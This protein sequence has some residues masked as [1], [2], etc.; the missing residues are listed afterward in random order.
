M[1]RH[2]Y[3]LAEKDEY[4]HWT[5][6]SSIG[7]SINSKKEIIDALERNWQWHNATTKTIDRGEYLDIE[8]TF[9][10]L[11]GNQLIKTFSY[12]WMHLDGAMTY[13]N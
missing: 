10:N 4:G 11:F 2:K 8:V 3:V 9:T 6:N 13:D 5:L 7:S 12:K 1:A